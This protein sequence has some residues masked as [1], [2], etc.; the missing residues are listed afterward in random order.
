MTGQDGPGVPAIILAVSVEF[1]V[2]S[3]DI[4]SQRRNVAAVRARHTGMWLARHL[5]LCSY[6]E[7]GR[8]FGRRDHST[9]MHAIK[10]I[11][12]HML[13]DPPFA[14]R[15]RALAR[16]LGDDGTYADPR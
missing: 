11:D 16:H 4:R 1:G 3:I 6:P 14:D 8:M 2:S 13:D 10:R 15:L 12:R 9:V 5:T 7:I